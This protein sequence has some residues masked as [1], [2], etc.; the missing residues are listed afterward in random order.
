VNKLLSSITGFR[1][2]QD[3]DEILVYH[4]TLSNMIETQNRLIRTIFNRQGYFSGQDYRNNRYINDLFDAMD[5]NAKSLAVSFLT[6]SS[7]EYLRN[8]DKR[9]IRNI[10]VIITIISVFLFS[11]FISLLIAKNISHTI[12][13]FAQASTRYSETGELIPD[14]NTSR[15]SELNKVIFAFTE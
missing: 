2:P 10:S 5:G 15:Y 3:Q 6:Y 8:L 14:I 1:P 13:L 11:L 12:Y 4:R 7:N 9:R